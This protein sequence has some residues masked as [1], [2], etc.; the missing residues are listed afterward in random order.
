VLE[1]NA[2][3]AA[4]W[5]FKENE[6]PGK[7]TAMPV[8][9]AL[10]IDKAHVTY[11]DPTTKTR[12][13]IDVSTVDA[14]KPNAGMLSVKGRGQYKAM[15]ATVD[16]LIGS[17]LALA[18]GGDKYPVKV[19]VVSGTTHA[20][21]DGNLIDPLHFKG[22]DLNFVLEGSDMAQ[23]FTLVGVP[24]PPTPPY[25]LSGHLNHTGDLWTF[26]KFSGTVGRSDLGGDFAVDR[27]QNPQLITANLVSKNLDM[28]DLG[29]FVGAKPGEHPT[30][31]A[32]AKPQAADKVLPQ[33]PFDLSKLRSANADVKFRGE[34]ILTE[35]LPLEKMTAN[36]KL[37]DGVLTFEPLSF[38]VAGGSLVSTISMDARKAVIA[39]RAD[40]A[41][42]QIH[43]EQLFPGVK[44]NKANVGVI[45]GRANVRGT[46]TSMAAILGTADGDAALIME[47][48]SVSELLVRL[49]NLDIANTLP[50]LLTGDKQVPVRCLVTQLKGTNG[51]FKMDPFVLDSDKAVVTGTGDIS[52]LNETLDLHLI[53][54]PKGFSLASLRGPINVS[55]TFKHP[56]VRP[57]VGRIVARAGAAVAL[58]IA[59]GGLG[60][61]IPLIDIG[62]AKDS[63]CAALVAEA[64]KRPEPQQ[65]SVQR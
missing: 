22:E 1:K 53:S 19:H 64:S 26:R 9:E 56:V 32:K 6:E 27:A 41:V 25:K 52:F 65:R 42:K 30:A 63:N 24:L 60:T 58:G 40:V 12:V 57:A 8:V 46:G 31:E 3:G 51:N 37:K 34:H 4:N 14:G 10:N 17:V 38:G 29:G 18:G 2:Q 62:G 21:L 45:G 35:K 16:G 11:R 13:G 7:Q 61:L 39:T 36:L 54:K 28:K 5:Q 48:G 49:S 50:V 23:L 47:G 44:M 20:R 15:T 33:E 43:L 59:T 55:G